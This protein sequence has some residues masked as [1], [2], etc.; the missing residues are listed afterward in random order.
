[1]GW[2]SEILAL[3][4]GM[5][6][7]LVTFGDAAQL[8]RVGNLDTIFGDNFWR[9]MDVIYPLATIIVFLL[10]G[11]VRGGIQIRP[12]SVLIFL[13]FAAALVMII[14]DDIFEVLNHPVTLSPTYWAA[15]RWTYPL[16]AGA[17]FLAF[18]WVCGRRKR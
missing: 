11:A 9:S 12:L 7:V 16:V 4:F 10:Y 14:I 13:A 8:D 5:L 18:G 17:S 3:V 1:M 2:K 15:A 6:L